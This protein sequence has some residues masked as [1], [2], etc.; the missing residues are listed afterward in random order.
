[1]TSRNSDGGA[2]AL[3]ALT[4]TIWGVSWVAMKYLTQYAGPFDVVFGRYVIAFVF[5]LGFMLATGRALGK[6]PLKLTLGVAVFQ[7]VGMQCFCQLALMSGGAGQV[8]LLA[9]TMPFWVIGFAWLMLGDRPSQRHV[10]G[11]ASAAIGLFCVIAPWR[12]LGSVSGSLFALAGGMS[13]GLGV[14][15]SKMLFQRYSPDVLAITTW[16]MLLGALITLPLAWVVPQRPIDWAPEFWWGMIY[17]GVVASGLGWWLWMTVVRRVSAAVVS[18][19]SLGVPVLTVVF[20][21]LLLGEQPGLPEYLG[22]VFILGGLLVVNLPVRR[23][24]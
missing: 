5:M 4:V 1:M 10:L 22:I 19:S 23:S 24:T 8:V 2:L 7:T 3:M 18:M 20:A 15:L 11:F 16:Q 21:W 17:T 12:G 9:Y 13:W 14:V 6:P